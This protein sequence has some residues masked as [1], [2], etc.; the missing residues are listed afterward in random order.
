MSYHLV[1][2][3]FKPYC[4]R[5]GVHLLTGDVHYIVFQLRNVP[6]DRQRK[7]LK[8]YYQEWLKGMANCHVPAKADNEGRRMANNW[9]RDVCGEE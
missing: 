8:G 9:L 6:L 2:T 4:L 7:V 3:A 1:E 5:N